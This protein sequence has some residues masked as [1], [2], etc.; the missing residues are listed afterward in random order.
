MS[1]TATPGTTTR[2]KGIVLYDGQCPLCQRSVAIL[3][4]LDWFGALHFQDARDTEHLPECD[5][6]L[7]PTRL[8]EEMHVVTP[9]RKH[10]YAG[11]LAFRWM[12]PRLPLVAPLTPLWYLPGVPWIGQKVYLWIAA[13]RY[14]LVPCKDGVCEMPRPAAKKK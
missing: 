8:L 4:R 12:S 3:R 7:E 1:T 6:P 2:R 11:F 13:N 9:N 14:N 10:A 5:V